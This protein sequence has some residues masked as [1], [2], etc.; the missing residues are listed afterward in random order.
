MQRGKC[1]PIHFLYGGG[2]HFLPLFSREGKMSYTSVRM[3]NIQL[4]KYPG[5]KVLS[6]L[7][8][9]R[10]VGSTSCVSYVEE[11][12]ACERLPARIDT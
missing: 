7:Y 9:G 6:S 1:P 10:H 2:S 4:R 8:I 11:M 12:S 5:E 3:V